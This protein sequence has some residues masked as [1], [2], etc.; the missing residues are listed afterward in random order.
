MSISSLYTK[1]RHLKKKKKKT[2]FKHFLLFC[3]HESLVFIHSRKL[4]IVRELLKQEKEVK[5]KW[6][7]K[8]SEKDTDYLFS[9]EVKVLFGFCE[10]FRGRPLPVD[11]AN[12]PRD[13]VIEKYFRERNGF[14]NKY[15]SGEQKNGVFASRAK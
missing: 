13:Q 11:T 10:C 12:I 5:N 8:S 14:K 7:M 9:S 4:Y 2:F 3:G 15:F 1:G 6:P